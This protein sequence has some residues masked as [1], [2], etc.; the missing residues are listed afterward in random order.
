MNPQELLELD[1]GGCV[2]YH[3]CVRNYSLLYGSYF[4]VGYSGDPRL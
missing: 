4:P 1:V 2:V 3:G